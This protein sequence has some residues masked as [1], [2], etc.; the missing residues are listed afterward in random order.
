MN[1]EE[2]LELN[3]PQPSPTPS[4]KPI[5]PHLQAHKSSK[6]DTRKFIELFLSTRFMSFETVAGRKLQLALEEFA[7][8]FGEGIADL[9]TNDKTF[10]LL[11]PIHRKAIAWMVC[12]TPPLTAKKKSIHSNLYSLIDYA[13]AFHGFKG[14]PKSVSIE[15]AAMKFL[16]RYQDKYHHLIAQHVP[17]EYWFQ[18]T[19][20]SLEVHKNSLAPISDFEDQIGSKAQ[21]IWRA[22][23]SNRYKNLFNTT[24]ENDRRSKAALRKSD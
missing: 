20:E 18:Y 10:A 12:N 15:L 1:F 21:T 3:L 22:I 19:P 23:R 5:H 7:F 24:V 6:E 11:E 16:T 13:S 8:G 14:Y 2:W 17:R 9:L 4:S